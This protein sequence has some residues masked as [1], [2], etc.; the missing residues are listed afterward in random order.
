MV[1]SFTLLPQGD[2]TRLISRN[3]I[4]ETG[5]SLGRRLADRLI[6]EPGSLVMERKMLRGIRARAQTSPAAAQA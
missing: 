2:G 1:W 3:R 5:A 6:M 4:A